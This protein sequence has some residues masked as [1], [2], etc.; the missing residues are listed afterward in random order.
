M[1]DTNRFVK[2]YS[3]VNSR[4]FNLQKYSCSSV[5]MNFSQ[6]CAYI[7]TLLDYQSNFNGKFIMF[8]FNNIALRHGNQ[9]ISYVIQLILN[10]NYFTNV[11]IDILL[12]LHFPGKN[13][14]FL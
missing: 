13:T 1:Y 6:S 8:M 4:P 9:D 14:T 7:Q 10:V 2:L 11:T 5:S 12:P 3:F